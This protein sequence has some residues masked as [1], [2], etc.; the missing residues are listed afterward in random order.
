MSVYLFIKFK[1]ADFFLSI[2]RLSISKSSLS[3]VGILIF[4]ANEQKIV[5]NNLANNLA[6]LLT[7]QNPLLPCAYMLT[8]SNLA[9]LLSGIAAIHGLTAR[10]PTHA[11]DEGP[12]KK[13][14]SINQ[15]GAALCSI[16]V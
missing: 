16:D 5:S 2:L 8:L 15:N 1:E 10:S 9:L 7:W 3:Q 4:L 14:N 12:N 13:K 6:F 11:K